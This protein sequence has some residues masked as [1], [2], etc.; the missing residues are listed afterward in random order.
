MLQAEALGGQGDALLDA[1]RKATDTQNDLA[2]DSHQVAT[3]II[4][5]LGGRERIA[6]QPEGAL[7]WEGT[8][9]NCSRPWNRKL[10]R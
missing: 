5:L 10:R 6:Q 7:F 1:Y 9:P 2:L 4:A 8:V 3:A